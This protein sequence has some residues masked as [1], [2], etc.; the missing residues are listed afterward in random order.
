LGVA[1]A[2]CGG[3]I[4]V[5]QR[6]LIN[7]AVKSRF[8]VQVRFA[9]SPPPLTVSEATPDQPSLQV[10]FASTHNALPHGI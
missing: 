9:A 3:A 10:R 5:L 6:I 2:P 1:V 4:A 7:Q 8:D